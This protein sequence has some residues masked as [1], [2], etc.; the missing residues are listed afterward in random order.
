MSVEATPLE[1]A[2]RIG[3]ARTA[4]GSLALAG[5][6]SGVAGKR[7]V[8]SERLVVRRRRR[9]DPVALRPDGCAG[10]DRSARGRTRD[11]DRAHRAVARA[12][13]AEP[14]R[15]AGRACVHPVARLRPVPHGHVRHHRRAGPGTAVPTLSGCSARTRAR[16]VRTRPAINCR[17]SLRCSRGTSRT[18]P[19]FGSRASVR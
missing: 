14:R 2:S 18:T 16:H 10:R 7:A 15:A 4:T 13:H 3:R 17:T 8:G 12:G 9:R 11:R 1:A 19:C 5:T 6:A